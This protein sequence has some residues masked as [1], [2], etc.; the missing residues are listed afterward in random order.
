MIWWSQKPLL[1]QMK[2]MC[3]NVILVLKKCAQ[4]EIRP[5]FLC[6]FYI[7]A[8]FDNL[9]NRSIRT[10]YP[11]TLT[12]KFTNQRTWNIF[13]QCFFFY[14][15]CGGWDFYWQH[16]FLPMEK[17]C[18]PDCTKYASLKVKNKVWQRQLFNDI[19]FIAYENS[20]THP[21]RD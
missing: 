17:R 19:I 5:Q 8:K 4:F 16:I 7:L 3:A 20:R 14:F 6:I 10:L 11:S 2:E 21:T 9:F 15:F 18:F 13:W 1:S 12:S